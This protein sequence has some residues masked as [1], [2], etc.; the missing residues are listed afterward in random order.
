MSES[1]GIIAFAYANLA[2]RNF[3]LK[4]PRKRANFW[5]W[6]WRFE[7]VFLITAINWIK[8]LLR[9]T[10]SLAQNVLN[11]PLQHQRHPSLVVEFYYYFSFN[12]MNIPLSL[13]IN[14][15]VCPFLRSKPSNTGL[16][17]TITELVPSLVIVTRYFTDIL[18]TIYGPII[19]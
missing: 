6:R 13:T 8:C 19:I 10:F 7:H 18:I 4:K 14:S 12:G 3:I 2:N 9:S 1:Q 5:L 16:G 15:N 11:M 17:N